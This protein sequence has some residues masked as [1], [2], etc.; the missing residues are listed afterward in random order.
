[1]RYPPAHPLS[2]QHTAPRL[3][4][5][6]APQR[7]LAVVAAQ[8]IEI[9]VCVLC[10]LCGVPLINTPN[11]KVSATLRRRHL[12][13]TCFTRNTSGLARSVCTRTHYFELAATRTLC[14]QARPS[15]GY[16]LLHHF[17]LEREPSH[18]INKFDVHSRAWPHAQTFS[19]CT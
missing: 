2:R 9:R 13:V 4:A 6:K 1:M 14:S 10:V 18:T 12:R 8:F 7:T 16:A 15:R 3:G 11:T 5:R 17:L 19:C